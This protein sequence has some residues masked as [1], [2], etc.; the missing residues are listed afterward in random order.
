MLI[1]NTALLVVFVTSCNPDQQTVHSD[2]APHSW[3]LEFQAF[4]LIQ[5]VQFE[6]WEK[7]DDRTRL[8][9]RFIVFDIDIMK[10]ILLILHQ[11]S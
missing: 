2:I 10:N 9:E 8:Q 1:R 5:L 7:R 3:F 4:C 6:N 11:K